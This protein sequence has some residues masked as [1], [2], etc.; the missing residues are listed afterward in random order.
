VLNKR[1]A[2][3]CK[4]S[5]TGSRHTINLIQPWVRWASHTSK[6]N[7]VTTNKGM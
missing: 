3:Y 2:K 4:Q 5:S 1:Q 7:T 6:K